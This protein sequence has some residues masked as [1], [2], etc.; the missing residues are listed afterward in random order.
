[1]WQQHSARILTAATYFPES[2]RFKYFNRKVLFRGIGKV[3]RLWPSQSETNIIVPCCIPVWKCSNGSGNK[4]KRT[5]ECIS[6]SQ[7][8]VVCQCQD[9]ERES[10]QIILASSAG[11]V[12]IKVVLM[13]DID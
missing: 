7:N 2:F 10:V 5:C 13:N 3:R 4:I 9:L 1:M 6:S 11:N 8:G 12:R